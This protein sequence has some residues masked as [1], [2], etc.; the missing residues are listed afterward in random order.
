MAQLL[1]IGSPSLDTIHVGGKTFRSVGGAG[2]YVAL[3]AVKS[4]T[5][6]SVLGLR[7]EPVPEEMQAFASQLEA[8]LGPVVP[9]ER[10][11]Q[12]E[13][14]HHGAEAR[15]L[16]QSLESESALDLT[17]LPAD[18][19][20]YDAVHITA[21]GSPATQQAFFHACR[22][23]QA[24]R[25]SLGTG[26]VNIS[27]EPALTRQLLEAADLFF[28]NEEEALTLFGSLAKIQIRP[29]QILFITRAEK[30]ALVFLGDFQTAIPGYPAALRDPTGAGETFCGAA[31]AHILQGE[32]PV[33]SGM[34]AAQLAAKKVAGIGAV[35]L[36]GEE[37]LPLLPLDQRVRIDAAQVKM[38]A[39][40]VRDLD[41]AASFNFVADYLPNIGDPE[42]VDYFFAATLQQFGFW[43]A[44]DGFYQKPLIARIDGIKCKGSEYLFRAF[45]RPLQTD[46]DFFT[47]E[48]QAVVTE[49]KL[50]ALFQAD[51]GQMPMPALEWHVQQANQYGQTMLALGS[52]LQG[53]LAQVQKTDRPLQ[54]LLMILDQLGGYR[55]D[56]IRKKASLLALIL[57]QRPEGFLAFGKDE[58][59]R[60]VVD[61]HCMRSVLRIGLVEVLDE[62]LKQKLNT[63]QLVTA[64]EEWVVRFA[65][66]QVLQA[67]VDLTGK[68]VGAVDWFFFN[69]MRSRCPEMT[70]PECGLCVL[71]GVCAKQKALFQPVFRTTNY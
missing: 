3:A 5:C 12:F 41:A 63:R 18:L 21:M 27:T 52:T 23:R 70:E 34:H 71:D 20:V 22:A 7:P 45:M 44:A 13:I 66:Y 37:P 38:V 49:A 9:V 60:P 40:V 42:T 51:D 32:H 6:V 36:L 11:P 15:Y 53:I 54:T 30:G 65:A 68:S 64:E 69:Y 26:V 35:D 55:E 48:R 1:V 39:D 58:A 16:R 28:M 59:V 46:R 4:G 14:A 33:M 56:P 24:R 50:A 31:L 61:Y 10:M 2:M 29:G 17:L 62:A 8:W 47:P 19:S 43:E 67:V 57:N 25:I